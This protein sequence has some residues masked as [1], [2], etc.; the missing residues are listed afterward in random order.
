MKQQGI[1]VALIVSMGVL[2][3]C[4]IGLAPWSAKENQPDTVKEAGDTFGTSMDK[5]AENADNPGNAVEA[6]GDGGFIDSNGTRDSGDA[7]ADSSIT[8]K[9]RRTAFC[10]HSA[11][12][13]VQIQI[14][15]CSTLALKFLRRNSRMWD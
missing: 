8:A 6:T 3:G 14:S 7:G 10:R 1:V 12:S 11:A 15:T 13:T 5:A 4:A 2:T 9:G